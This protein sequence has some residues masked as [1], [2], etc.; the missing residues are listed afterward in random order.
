MYSRKNS[1]LIRYDIIGV[2]RKIYDIVKDESLKDV[3]L[4]LI[5]LEKE[6]KYQTKYISLWK[7]VLKQATL[8]EG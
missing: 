6:K 1:T 8:K 5:S 4:Q 3:S 7:D 2:L